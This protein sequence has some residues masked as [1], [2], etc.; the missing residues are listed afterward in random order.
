MLRHILRI[1]A[2][3][4]LTLAAVACSTNPATGKMQLNTL[5]EPQEIQ[6]GT[7]AQPQFIEQS[8]GLVPDQP[9]CAYVSNLGSRL[10]KLSERPD[11]PWEFN[12]LNTDQVNAFALPGGKI[13]ITRGLLSRM[14]NEAQL[15]GV[16]GHE[17]GHVNAEHIGQQMTRATI[18]SAGVAILGAA[19]EKDWLVTLGGA[20]GG[21]YM[22][23]F[24]RDQE[25]QADELG[26]RYMTKVGYNPQAQIQVME[27]LQKAAGGGGALE[28]FQTHPNPG[29][30]IKDLQKLIPKDYAYTQNNPQFIFNEQPFQTNVLS[31]LAKL[32][33]A[34]KKSSE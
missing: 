5:S 29:N 30:R 16:L 14:S 12:V 33:P 1:A 10:A 34:P 32:P 27:I 4:L 8:G 18:I 17:I 31:R 13:F 2:L 20:T 15:A 9:L 6:L 25:S 19:T 7:E 22:L 23:S 24:S 11:L 3:L 28:I 21:I 26:V